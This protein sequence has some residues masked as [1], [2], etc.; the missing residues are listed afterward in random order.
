M[1]CFKITVA[2]L[3]LS[4]GLCAGDDVSTQR[5][6]IYDSSQ[7]VEGDG[8]VNSYSLLSSDY[9]HL[10]NVAHGSGSFSQKS[11]VHSRQYTRY[12]ISAAGLSNTSDSEIKLDQVTDATYSP[13][14][15]SIGKNS[16]TLSFASRWSED[17]NIKNAKMGASMVGNLDH[18]TTMGNDISTRLYSYS[19]YWDADDWVDW[20]DYGVKFRALSDSYV[21]E[22]IQSASLKIGSDFTGAAKFYA[23]EAIDGPKNARVLVDESYLGT[24]SLTKNMALS[25]RRFRNAHDEGW[26]PCCSGGWS[27][28]D[29]HDRSGYGHS[30]D[31]IFDCT[32]FKAP[33]SAQFQRGPKEIAN[34][35][36]ALQESRTLPHWW[37]AGVIS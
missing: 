8:F 19:D 29:I 27:E 10:K 5:R 12:N 35:P 33:S 9:L 3:I 7:S 31:G 36:D 28:M 14:S 25:D 21:N 2:L 34:D 20:D 24:F 32:C 1:S 17:T 11:V 15:L 37:T 4:V 18:A 16:R 26:L 23:V 22:S 6:Y 30:A 13:E